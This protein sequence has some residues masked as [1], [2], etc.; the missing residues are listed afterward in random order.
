MNREELGTSQTKQNRIQ[1]TKNS[2]IKRPT[3]STIIMTT[4]YNSLVKNASAKFRMNQ[5]KIRFFTTK[6]TIKAKQGIEICNQL[7]YDKYIIEDI[8]L[9]VSNGEDYLGKT[10]TGEIRLTNNN[11]I[12]KICK[13]PR[14]PYPGKF[15]NINLV[16][17][18]ESYSEQIQISGN[19]QSSEQNNIIGY[20]KS[21]NNYK[22][23]GIFPILEG[24]V[25][26]NIRKVIK[27]Y[28][29]IKEYC[30][31]GYISFD[32]LDNAEFPSTCIKLFK[33]DQNLWETAI[34]REC[35]GLIISPVTGNILSRR[36]HKFFNINE[37]EETY[38][39]NINLNNFT[40][41]EK[42]DGILI[43]PIL[44]DDS[45][46]IW[47]SRKSEIKEVVEFI[48]NSKIK[49]NDFSLNYLTLGITPLFEWCH[50]T[51]HVGVLT[52]PYKQ[53]ILT[54]LRNN[55]T[56]QY[57]NISEISQ[58]PCANVI[59]CDNFL[60]LLTNIR[61]S[62][63]REG[64]VISVPTGEK[65]KLKS[66]WYV[67]MVK[68][69][70]YGGDT[71]FLPEIIKLRGSLK[72]IPANKIWLT[73]L[74]NVDDV[75][76]LCISMLL[77]EDAQEFK[78]FVHTLKINLAKLIHQLTVW[79]Y[80]Q[81]A[82][83]EDIQP[84]CFILDECGYPITIAEAV[85]NGTDYTDKFIQFLMQLAKRK[86]IQSLDE[87][88]D[89]HWNDE[90]GKMEINNSILDICTF[91]IC[92][93]KIIDH[94][95]TTYFPK[96]ISNMLGIKHITPETTITISRSYSASEGK[97]V[98][99]WEI[100]TKDNIYDLRIDLQPPQK[101]GYNDHYGNSEYALFL[102]QYGLFNN[103]LYPHGEFA[104]IL[105]PTDESI[106]VT[107]MIS[108][109]EHSFG[110]H[111]LIKLRRKNM[112]CDKDMQNI[113]KIFC[114]LDGV[115]VDFEKGIQLLTGRSTVSQSASKMWQRISTKKNF[116]AS[117]DFMP[118]GDK[119]WKDICEIG[120]TNGISTPTILTGITESKNNYDKDKRQ[121]C[122]NN[123]GKDVEVITC[124][125]SEKYKYA[126]INHILIDDRIENCN[127]WEKHGGICIRHTNND[128]TI[129]ELKKV[130]NM[131]KKHTINIELQPSEIE[132]DIYTNINQVNIITNIFPKIDCDLISI[133]CEWTP[134]LANDN[135]Y[136][137]FQFSTNDQTYL[138]DNLNCNQ[139]V[140]E[141][142]YKL[143]E[144]PNITKLCWGMSTSEI[145]KI[146]CRIINCVDLQEYCVDNFD[147]LIAN[148]IPSLYSAVYALLGIKMNKS[149]ELQ[150]GDWNQRPLSD[151]QIEYAS[152]DVTILFKL[153]D[154]LQGIT[155]LPKKNIEL[156]DIKHT[157][158]K[159]NDDFDINTPVKLLYYGIFLS[160][161][162]KKE[163]LRLVPPVHSKIYAS[164]VTLIY[165]PSERE[166]R[167]IPIGEITEIYVTG[168][169]QAEH[170]QTVCCECFKQKYHITISTD[171][172]TEPNCSSDI[173][174][175]ISIEPIQLFGTVG[176]QTIAY[177]DELASLPVKTKSKLLDFQ[178]NGLVGQSLKFKPGE[179]SSSERA[180]IHQFA[181]NNNIVSQSSGPD[182]KRQLI[183]T[184]KKYE[185]KTNSTKHDQA[186][187]EIKK[188]TDF[189]Q[190]SMLHIINTNTEIITK[191][192]I[193]TSSLNIQHDILDNTLIILR[194]LP[195]SGK[196][197]ICKINT[198]WTYICSAD[199]YFMKSGQYEFNKNLLDQAHQYCFQKVKNGLDL[200]ENIIVVDNT[201]S[202]Q[203]EYIKYKKI[204]SYYN[205]NVV[206]IE[207]YCKDRDQAIMFASRNSH[208]V[209][210]GT[211]LKMLARWEY[212]SD[213]ILVSP[214]I[215]IKGEYNSINIYNESL[216]KWLFD[217][218]LFHFNKHRKYTHMSFEIGAKPCIY[219]NIP[220][221]L[222]DEFLKRYIASG[223]YGD[224]TD[225]PK[226]IMENPNSAETFRMFFNIDYVSDT[227]LDTQYILK[228]VNILQTFISGSI[229]VT[230]CISPRFDKIK[231]GLHFV[232]NGVTTNA[233]EAI[234]LYNG[235]IDLLKTELP[236]TSITSS[237][238]DW[239]SWI[240]S[241]VYGESRGM[242][243]L[244][245]R[246]TIK[247]IDQKR[248]Y[249]LFFVVNEEGKI[250]SDELSDFEL[251][252][253]NSVFVY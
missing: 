241:N 102:V 21:K 239:E 152:N 82:I 113:Y 50:D 219:I 108:A 19:A 253:N 243:M 34:V 124:K 1:L 89:I 190:F 25:L 140:Q 252:K 157:K 226:Y 201:N 150:A 245:S 60:D 2:A 15:Q 251:M 115:L 121:W 191:G 250:S 208:Q 64:V 158:N 85:M 138:I 46:L 36:Y 155:M 125:S 210:I 33:N 13:P 16:T 224:E 192:S 69:Q 61:E 44:L 37:R 40:V 161:Q 30:K 147:I 213:A 218:K 238:I 167:G 156:T 72:N 3:A 133:D 127:L 79:V 172:N 151:E 242:R 165:N 193:T 154:K 217:N 131:H 170:I 95:L 220:D 116:F 130:F 186:Q 137:I 68:G 235:Y 99:M 114:D 98:G 182:D 29:K 80:D 26:D 174:N 4:D 118:D 51:K 117:L 169:S 134:N 6:N 128:R 55:V 237:P 178:Q 45:S 126:D 136:S 76:A 179:F 122:A 94:V 177:I 164:H 202:T 91:H 63:N 120:G 77:D 163:L 10:N 84:I 90:T 148:N 8:L 223:I 232:C 23:N 52:Y 27:Q 81:Y 194:G 18:D 240:D 221:D 247:G 105:V 97:I 196:S 234:Y 184:K 229:Y 20:S 198:M 233:E 211:T 110:S 187:S 180:I 200:N 88:L 168:I 149:K 175:W 139:V 185:P 176:V 87:L 249:K 53:L 205:Y 203:K 166:L 86:H 141:Q 65:Y 31:N 197:H 58:V 9:A 107:D 101:I 28:P 38:L 42:L 181:E 207:I 159:K 204:A 244:G 73:A 212:D 48:K 96:K 222:Y 78:L 57:L 100:F 103:V 153:Y 195:G 106:K 144:N 129:Y 93:Q 209:P 231:T 183:L 67:D 112:S 171:A 14:H 111:K 41:H 230:G 132:T 71:N 24:N 47:A 22:M 135:T 39:E 11:V 83:V 7:D 109:L 246:K 54:G 74:Q 5:Q 143:L 228:M 189:Y 145:Q 142:L 162:S 216:Y 123:L 215:E 160:E 214:Y 70:M 188:I 199:D 62:V 66:Y 225:E 59:C 227:P 248:I 32:Y 104:G 49:Y 56:G 17:N 146:G 119:L 43:S 35:R 12:Y 173:R 236:C 206:V 75:I 92:D